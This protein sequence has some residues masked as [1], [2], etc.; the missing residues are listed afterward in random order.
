MKYY[1]GDQIENNE[2]GGHVA[3][4]EE[5]RGVYRILVGKPEKK[6]PFGKPILIGG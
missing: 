6:R 4:M 1:L 3:P 5:M 2:F